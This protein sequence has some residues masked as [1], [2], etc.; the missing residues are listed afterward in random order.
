MKKAMRRK[1]RNKG[2]YCRVRE[3]AEVGRE[4]SSCFIATYR[5]NI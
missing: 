1:V 2:A 4:D 3:V 5:D